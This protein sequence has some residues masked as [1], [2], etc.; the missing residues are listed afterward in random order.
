MFSIVPDFGQS[1]LSSIRV[2]VS[3]L[4]KIPDTHFVGHNDSAKRLHRPNRLGVIIAYS[5]AGKAIMS[6]AH[7]FT[8][9]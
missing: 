6:S 4:H 8:S 3:A 1:R 7:F 2:A 5:N 9:C